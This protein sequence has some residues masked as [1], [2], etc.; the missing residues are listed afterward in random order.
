MASWSDH[1]GPER[2]SKAA[3]L[4]VA[5]LEKWLEAINV[6]RANRSA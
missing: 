5:A 2:N 1:T 3:E 4:A 6:T